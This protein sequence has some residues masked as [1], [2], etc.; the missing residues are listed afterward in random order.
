MSHTW[1]MT[2][3]NTITIKVGN[4]PHSTKNMTEN[5]EEVELAALL[6][7]N[8]AEREK[9]R[10]LKRCQRNKNY[11]Q[12]NK[13]LIKE[14]SL[15]NYYLKR[16]EKKLEEIQGDGAEQTTEETERYSTS[17]FWVS[18]ALAGVAVWLLN[19][20]GPRLP[21]PPTSPGTKNLASEMKQSSR[22]PSESYQAKYE[23][24][25]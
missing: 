20:K 7:N 2:M 19:R 11:Y 17:V 22:F 4:Q 6:V 18:F 1:A 10:G 23:G 5:N 12:K 21:P 16:E 3:K 13:E 25:G 15:K 9:I 24:H 14:R 8:L